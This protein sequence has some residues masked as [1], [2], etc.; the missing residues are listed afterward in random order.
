MNTWQQT[1]NAVAEEFSDLP[2]ISDAAAS[3]APGTRGSAGRPA[4]L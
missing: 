2:E 1:A 4:G 3:V